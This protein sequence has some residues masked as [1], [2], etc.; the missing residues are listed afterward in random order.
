MKG[1]AFL[2]FAIRVE[3]SLLE[4]RQPFARAALDRTIQ[5]EHASLLRAK[6][7]P[8]SPDYR[9]PGNH[10]PEDAKDGTES[11]KTEGEPQP[12]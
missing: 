6:V 3:S 9:R 2:I 8:L 5:G 1:S 4:L 12:E 11:G 10:E 7:S